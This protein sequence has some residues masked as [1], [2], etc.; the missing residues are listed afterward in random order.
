MIRPQDLLMIDLFILLIY[1]VVENFEHFL[2]SLV[3][4]TIM[5]IFAFIL[6]LDAQISI[7]KIFGLLGFFTMQDQLDLLTR[8]IFLGT[9]EI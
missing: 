7:S 4:I 5:V 1:V 8:L 3:L 9:L 6:F 2:P